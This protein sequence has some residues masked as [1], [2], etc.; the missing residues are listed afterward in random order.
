MRRVSDYGRRLPSGFDAVPAVLSTHPQIRRQQVLFE[1]LNRFELAIPTDRY[2]RTAEQNLSRWRLE[3]SARDSEATAPLT[4]EVLPLDWGEATLMLTRRH[5]Q[6]FAV[7][8]MAN[9]VVPGGN[10]VEGAPA[11]EENMFRRTDCHFSLDRSQMHSVTERYRPRITRL[12][13]ARDGR[14]MLDMASPRTCLR[15]PEDRTRSDLGYRWLGAEEIFPF[16]ELRAAAVRR[17]DT[18]RFAAGEMRRRI[19]AQLDTLRSAGVRH[20]VLGAFG[21]GAFGNPAEQVARIYRDEIQCRA[22]DFS[23]I[24]FAIFDADYE[25]D[26][27]TPFA[28]AFA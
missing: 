1:T 27:F 17:A 6:R 3:A 19:A 18:Q 10:Y 21:C 4:I 2:H 7:L 24:A 22:T 20:A 5:G 25:P 9:P 8:N 15:G 28:Q 16:L 12:L 23:V 26:N 11:Q 14:V 13:E